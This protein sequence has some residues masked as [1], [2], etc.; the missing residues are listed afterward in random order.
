MAKI[1]LFVIACQM[2]DFSNYYTL[3]YFTLLCYSSHWKVRF[4]TE[5]R[6]GQCNKMAILWYTWRDWQPSDDVEHFNGQ[7]RQGQH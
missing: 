6:S 3:K 7:G 1:E 5:S 2:E 4:S